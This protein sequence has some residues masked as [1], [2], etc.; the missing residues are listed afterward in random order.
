MSMSF[1]FSHDGNISYFP[2]SKSTRRREGGSTILIE[3]DYFFL[4]FELIELA[5]M[6]VVSSLFLL[7]EER[8]LNIGSS[9]VTN[10]KL[11]GKVFL[12]FSRQSSR[13]LMSD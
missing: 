11:I 4:L 10:S 5:R 1:V 3:A 7:L 9:S 6:R 12:F 13:E 2:L 8:R